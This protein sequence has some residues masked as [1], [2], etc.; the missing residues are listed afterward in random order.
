LKAAGFD[1]PVWNAR[2][3]ATEISDEAAALIKARSDALSAP[4][5]EELLELDPQLGTIELAGPEGRSLIKKHLV[6]ERNQALAKEETGGTEH[7][8]RSKAL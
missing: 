6:R 2:G 3:N 4:T 7:H 5:I 8:R 1:R